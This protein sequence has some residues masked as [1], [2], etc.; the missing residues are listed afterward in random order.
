MGFYL[1]KKFINMKLTVFCLVVLFIFGAFLVEDNEA[2]PKVRAQPCVGV[3]EAN[4]S[5]YYYPCGLG[6]TTHARRRRFLRNFKN[7]T[8]KER[9]NMICDFCK[10]SCYDYVG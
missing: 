3:T 2:L 10:R 1:N 6:P 4:C 5:Y 7:R 9:L 8:P